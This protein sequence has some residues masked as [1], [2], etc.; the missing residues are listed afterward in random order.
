[1]K[2]QNIVQVIIFLLGLC[3]FLGAFLLDDSNVRTI[4]LSI[5]CSIVAVVIINFVEYQITL[6]EVNFIKKMNSWK[7][8]EIFETR[9]KMNDVTNRLLENADILDIAAFGCKGFIN[10][11][12]ELLVKRLKGGMKIRFLVPDKDSAFIRQREIDEEVTL[13]EIKQTIELLIKWVNKV[14]S[15]ND[16]KHDQIIMKKYS[17]LPIDSIMIIDDNL[18]TGPF[19]TKKISQLTMAYQYKKGGIGYK[20]YKD[21]FDG[22]WN[23]SEISTLIEE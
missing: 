12:N 6:P 8:I 22:I 3:M 1:M 16:L 9:Q 11:N 13:G 7:L 10:Y 2:R 19:M 21:Y 14:K 17:C 15:D 5:G 20:Y 23:D 18:F 4:L